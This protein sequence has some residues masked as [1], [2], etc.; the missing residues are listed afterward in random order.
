MAEGYAT[1]RPPVHAFV[2]DR[3]RQTLGDRLNSHRVLDAGCGAGL[4]T[5]PLVAVSEFCLGIEPVEAMLRFA[6][7]VAPGARF[8]AGAAEALPVRSHT[9]DL[10]TAAGSLN[11][12]NL[13]RFFPEAA[14]VLAP[15]GFLVVYDFS[16]G[17]SFRSSEELDLWFGHFHARYPVLISEATRLT[18]EILE[19]LDSGFRLEDH[20]YFETGIQM[21][22]GAYAAYMM[23]E[24]NVALALR[25]G[26]PEAEIREWVHETLAPVFD[27]PEREVLF[28]GY[29]ACMEP[30]DG[31]ISRHFQG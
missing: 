28:R 4:S 9:F 18:P 10:I 2:L 6:P 15:G 21:T 31:T 14:R 29:F 22:P 16:P 25:E 20:E 12:V 7:G 3:V 13:G 11:Y 1:A 5:K 19:R 23:T 17:K 27:G 24:T 26:T 8:A 30:V